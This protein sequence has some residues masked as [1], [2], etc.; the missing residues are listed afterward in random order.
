MSVLTGISALDILF[1]Q[2]GRS[3]FEVSNTLDQ[4]STLRMK[5]ILAGSTFLIFIAHFFT[6]FPKILKSA[7]VFFL[8]I[9]AVYY[10]SLLKDQMKNEFNGGLLSKN[11]VNLF[12]K[13]FCFVKQRSLTTTPEI[14]ALSTVFA[15]SPSVLAEADYNVQ[16]MNAVGVDCLNPAGKQLILA[17]QTVK[18]LKSVLTT[19]PDNYINSIPAI[20]F[21]EYKER[22]GFTADVIRWLQN[23]GSANSSITVEQFGLDHFKIM[24]SPSNEVR[25]MFVSMAYSDGWRAISGK[26]VMIIREANDFGFIINVPAGCSNVMLY[27]NNIHKFVFS[28]ILAFLSFLGAIWTIFMIFHGLKTSS[29]ARNNCLDCLA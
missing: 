21:P 16:M 12:S 10:S 11:I 7:F 19:S 17:N 15:S 8:I 13:P 25:P 3:L 1:P 27:Y 4:Y 26:Q 22:L 9:S 5:G 20:V 2:I 29:F 6:Y 23:N 24:F 28:W 14:N 18:Y